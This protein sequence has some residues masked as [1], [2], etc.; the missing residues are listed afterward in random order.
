METKIRPRKD[1]GYSKCTS[2]DNLVSKGRCCHIL[3]E[4]EEPMELVRVERGLYVVKIKDSNMTIQA[5][6]QTIINFFNSLPKIDED[7]QKKILEF[8]K[9]S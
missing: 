1:G 6:K 5:Q 8:L 4:D 3:I 2:P 9:E 7:K